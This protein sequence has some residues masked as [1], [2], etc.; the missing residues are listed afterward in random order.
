M[1]KYSRDLFLKIASVVQEENPSEE[2]QQEKTASYKVQRFQEKLAELQL[3]GVL[4]QLFEDR[5]VSRLVQA[6]MMKEAAEVARPVVGDYVADTLASLTPLQAFQL[7]ER[8]LQG[9][10]LV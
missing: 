3:G 6:G 4:A 1:P 9:K 10:R 7:A 2:P 5:V 8:A